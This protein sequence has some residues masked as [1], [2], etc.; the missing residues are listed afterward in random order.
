[1]IRVIR[2]VQI[3]ILY[4]SKKENGRADALSRKNDHMKEKEIFK[5]SILKVNK[6][7]S[8]SASKH[9]LRATLRILRDD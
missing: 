3:Q 1:M 7:E 6:N 2:T 8:L 9:E 5:E 4:T